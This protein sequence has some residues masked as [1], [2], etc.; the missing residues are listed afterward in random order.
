M[1]KAR[2]H[3]K[4]NLILETYSQNLKFMNYYSSTN[5]NMQDASEIK[6]KVHRMFQ[7]PHR[8]QRQVNVHVKYHGLYYILLIKFVI[9]VL[10]EIKHFH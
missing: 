2:Y 3:L 9:L 7:A 4:R 1:S 8:K 10:N 5:P 6:K